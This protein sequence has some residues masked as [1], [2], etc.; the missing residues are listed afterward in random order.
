MIY[1]LVSSCSRSSTLRIFPET[2]L[3]KDSRNRSTGEL[4]RNIEIAKQ[5]VEFIKV[6]NADNIQDSL[7]EV[8]KADG[9][10]I[11]VS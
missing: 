9:I 7:D 1:F 6:H 8:L 2:V 4:G 3:G 5:A 10:K 11:L